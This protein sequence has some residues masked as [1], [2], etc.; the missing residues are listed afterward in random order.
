MSVGLFLLFFDFRSAF[1]PAGWKSVCKFCS[2]CLQ[3]L[4]SWFFFAQ[5]MTDQQHVSLGSV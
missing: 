3:S 4:L 1:L 2:W 5:P